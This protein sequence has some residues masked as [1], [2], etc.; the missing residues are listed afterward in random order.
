MTT[1]TFT[2][3]PRMTAILQTAS[4]ALILHVLDEEM[5]EVLKQCVDAVENELDVKPEIIMFGKIC[6]QARSVG[7]Y[8]N[9]SK[10]FNY[11]T[12]ITPSKKMHPSLLQL[13][14][15]VNERFHE[16]YNGILIN[17]Y[18]DGKDYIGKH[19]DDER[20]LGVS[21]GVIVLSYGAVRT[22]RVRN[23]LTGK[24]MMDVPTEPNVII[25]MAGEFQKEFTHEIPIQRKCK[26]PRYSFT[27]RK[28]QY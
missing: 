4:S 3:Q 24:I 18:D 6:H 2:N 14:H 26:E 5:R 25:Q 23:K 10:G 16:N 21:Q 13:L 11:S 22:F 19:S 12:T 8:S 9:V 7:F 20:G 15:Q 17:K 27:F 1:T 28:H